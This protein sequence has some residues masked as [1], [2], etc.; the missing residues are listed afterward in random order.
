MLVKVQEKKVAVRYFSCQEDTKG[1]AVTTEHGPHGLLATALRATDV[2]LVT[3]ETRVI[4]AR[5]E[6]FLKNLL[7]KRTRAST[8]DVRVRSMRPNN[9]TCFMRRHGWQV[10][11]SLDHEGEEYQ[12]QVDALDFHA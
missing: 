9:Q 6:T 10:S 12:C 3:E 1:A 7:Q 2:V 4:V 8:N 5:L 11:E